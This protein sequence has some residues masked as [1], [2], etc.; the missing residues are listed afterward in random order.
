[1]VLASGQGYADALFGSTL[2]SQINSPLLLTEKNKL[3]N[4]VSNEIKGLG[5][6]EVFI[7]GGE[8]TISKN[9]EKELYALGIKVSRLTGKDRLE[10]AIS[11]ANSYKSILG[12]NPDTIVL[13]NG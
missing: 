6:K 12:I 7:L 9:V 3:S 5:V 11:V 10:T 1:M 4:G 2:S 8:N 13:V